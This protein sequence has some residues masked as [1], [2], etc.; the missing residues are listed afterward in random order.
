MRAVATADR[1]VSPI[2]LL[3][4]P[5]CSIAKN[6]SLSI[7][8]IYITRKSDKLACVQW[9]WLIWGKNQGWG[10]SRII[11]KRP[12]IALIE[13]TCHHLNPSKFPPRH[14]HFP[15]LK[16]PSVSVEW[17]LFQVTLVASKRLWSIS[18]IICSIEGSTPGTMNC[19]K[20]SFSAGNS[21]LNFS[22]RSCQ[23]SNKVQSLIN[24]Q[25]ASSA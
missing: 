14:N 22:R 1:L 10:G 19:H 21:W 13:T 5:L 7:F 24:S 17:I 9:K 11:K 3:F 15:T 25:Q 12:L 4:F 8:A 6:S 18:S 2:H 20:M 16:P 23:P